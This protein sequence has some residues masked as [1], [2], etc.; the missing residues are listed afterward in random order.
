MR[1]HSPLVLYKGYDS[2][3]LKHKN[4]VIFYVILYNYFCVSQTS[5]ALCGSLITIL[6]T[7]S[8]NSSWWY[9]YAVPE[10]LKNILAYPLQLYKYKNQRFIP[11][12]EVTACCL[13]HSLNSSLKIIF[14]PSRSYG[15]SRYSFK[16]A[17]ASRLV[18]KPKK[19]II[20]SLFINRIAHT[21]MPKQNS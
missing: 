4:V 20:E 13:N 18:G 10:F 21:L 11:F 1:P 2:R 19:I 6:A 16:A 5:S 12:S 15:F 7:G 9:T 3:L 14:L 17:S 8:G